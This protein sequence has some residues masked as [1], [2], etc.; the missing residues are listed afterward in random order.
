L[1]RAVELG[2]GW[3]PIGL[4]PDELAGMLARVERAPGSE[5]VLS[6]GRRLD[7]IGRRD[8]VATA[9]LGL[10]DAG[11]TLVGAHVAAGSV[12]HYCGQLHA[13]KELANAVEAAR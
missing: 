6:A 7:L 13:L 12:D 9:L 5:V 10:A 2:D 11:A 3:V 4:S 8:D 1:R